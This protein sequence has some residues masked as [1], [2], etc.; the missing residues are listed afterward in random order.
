MLLALAAAGMQVTLAAFTATTFNPGNDFQAASSFSSNNLLRMASGFYAGNGADDRAIS[1]GFQPDLVIVKDGGNREGVARTSTMPGD[2]S[3]PMGTLTG[4]EADHIQSL[5]ASGFTIGT[6]NKVNENGKI[7]YWTAFM[8]SGQ[9]MK[10]GSYPGNATGQ[11]ITGAGFSPEYVAVLGATPQRAVQRFSGMSRTFR[12]D[13][14][15]G[16][17]TGITSLDAD[18]F[19]VGTDLEVNA[20]ATTYHYVAFND[21]AGSIKVGSY[22]GTGGDNRNITPPNFQPGY[23]LIRAN[24]TVTGRP[25]AHRPAS[26]AGDS[27]LFFAGSASAADRIQA[28]QAAGFQ[29]G[30]SGNVNANTIPYHYLAAA[31]TGGGCSL[32]TQ[33]V[34]ASADSWIDEA[35]PNNNLGSDSV[36]KVTTK[37]PASN[38]R[39]VLQFNLPT[40]P[41][42]CSVTGATL[43]FYNKAP[44]AG[45]TLEALANSAAWTEN[46]ATWANQP[47]TTGSAS[48]AATP[49]LAG[50]MQWDVSTQVQGMYSGSNNGF[51]VRD[52]TEDGL[53]VEQQFDSRESGV[54]LPQLVVDFG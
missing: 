5:T 26:L 6:N 3:K 14:G 19:T 27:T 9:T 42:G 31:N 32:R 2:A 15:T 23:V 45:R 24:D 10:V 8:A 11:P 39:A 43:R 17:T 41:P 18:G 21:I 33:M 4:L 13:A 7:Y 47:G 38:T 36:L 12:F 51:K 44:I 1:A 30:T 53:G 25:T 16:T 34:T 29:L 52:Q 50:W 54:N 22:S 20:A 35:S 37:S 40:V 49:V 46:G 48:T 28:L